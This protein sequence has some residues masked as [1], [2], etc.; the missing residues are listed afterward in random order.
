MN[1]TITKLQLGLLT[2]IAIFTISCEREKLDEVMSKENLPPVSVALDQKVEVAGGNNFTLDNNQLTVP[3]TINFSGS[4]S[5]AFTVQMV[6]NTEI[7]ASLIANNTLPAGTVAL[8]PDTYDIPPVVNVPYGVTS[9]TW[10]L[11]LGRTFLEK[12]HGKDVALVVTMV[13]A[14]KG[15]SIT[16]GKNS[17]IVV[18]KTGETIALEDV[19]YITVGSKDGVVNIPFPF[20]PE[21]SGFSLSS[22]DMVIPL[23]LTLSGQAGPAFTVEA[24][25]SAEIVNEA[26]ASGKL[27]NVVPLPTAGWSIPYPKVG[28]EANRNTAPLDINVRLSSIIFST[29]KKFAIG[30]SLKNPS[31]YQLGK[32]NNNAIIVIDPDYFRKPFNAAPFVIKGTIGEA[33]ARIAASNYDFGGQGIAFNDDGGRDGGPFRRPD[34]VDIADNQVTVGWCNSGEWLTYTVV[35]EEDGEYEFNAIIGAPGTNGRYSLFFGDERVTGILSAKQ[36]PG[37]YGDQQPNLSTVN[38]KKGKHVMR[39]FMDVGA[40]DVQGYIFTRKK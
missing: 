13:D 22:Q 28:F 15:N 12:N 31:K 5:R 33:S 25:K 30:V 40:Y 29:G 16:P 32:T 10:N 36:T 38:L 6:G 34:N 20:L 21:K 18:V 39:F 14:A 8:E 3:I 19:H 35:V 9:V 11:L 37:S 4:T 27:T 26:I 2:A 1:R 24:G 7:I 23:E 17:I